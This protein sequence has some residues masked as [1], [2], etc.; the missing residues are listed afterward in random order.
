MRRDDGTGHIQKYNAAQEAMINMGCTQTGKDDEFP[1]LTAAD[2]VMKYT[3][4]PHALGDG[5]KAMAMIWHA[6]GKRKVP[7]SN[8][9]SSIGMSCPYTRYGL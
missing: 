8:D 7:I 3:E 5:S 6:G 9:G 1:Q 4:R 2:A